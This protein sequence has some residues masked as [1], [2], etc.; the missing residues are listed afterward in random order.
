MSLINQMLQDLEK[1]GQAGNDIPAPRYTQF[2]H[3]T[4]ASP[5]PW[6]WRMLV[7]LVLGIALVWVYVFH[8]SLKSSPSA[9]V[10]TAPM[11]PD[12]SIAIA[13][14]STPTSIPVPA[15]ATEAAATLTV[16]GDLSLK[17]TKDVDVRHV[18]VNAALPSAFETSV[19]ETI[20][21]K[22]KPSVS[23]PVMQKEP[24]THNETK[25]IKSASSATAMSSS[26]TQT[27]AP[28]AIVK[29]T[30]PLQRAETEYRQATSYLQQ[31]RH[32]EALSALQQAL[33]LDP[34][35][36]PARQ[37]LI[38][39]LIENNRQEDAMR[40]LKHGLALDPHQSNFAMTLARLQVE[41]A[42]VNEAIITLQAS[43][44]AGQDR[45]DYL[46]FLAALK[47]KTGAH[48][49]AIQ[50][51]R[52]A[53]KKHQA[54]GVWWMGLGISLQADGRNPDALDAYRR[55]L[56]GN[57]LSADLQAFVE[58]KVSQLPH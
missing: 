21:P 18:A 17:L 30:S 32:S 35:H 36:A 15:P 51:Y 11:K 34:Q 13:P 41:R 46:A 47:Q 1:R 5:H 50:L 38:S 27:A 57:G 45:A 3:Q 42:N 4:A 8:G 12:A 54:N 37:A 29:E 43:L 19:P 26:T 48:K 31:G 25:P 52:Q 53:L 14:T 44:P 23:A 28:V 22:D 16:A 9:L 20:S 6:R 2:T 39:I 7:L 24:L 56:A 33:K 55:A 40:E 49:E 10:S 58:Q